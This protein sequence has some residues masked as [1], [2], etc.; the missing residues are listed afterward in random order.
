VLDFP[1]KTPK[2]KTQKEF[3][4]TILSENHRDEMISMKEK[5][6]LEQRFLFITHK[7]NVAEIIDAYEDDEK[8]CFANKLFSPHLGSQGIYYKRRNLSGFTY[9]KKSKKCSLWYGT[10][11]KKLHMLNLCFNH[12]KLDWVTKKTENFKSTNRFGFNSFYR[13]LS[14]TITVGRLNKI[15]SGKISSHRE[16]IEDYN[17]FSLRDINVSN[18]SLYK[19]ITF[20]AEQSYLDFY[21]ALRLLRASINPDNVINMNFLNQKETLFNDKHNI[22]M[23][24]VDQAKILNVKFNPGWS[25]KRL[26]EVHNNWT[27][28]LTGLEIKA[29][30]DDKKIEFNSKELIEEFNEFELLDSKY[31][32]FEEGYNQRH[33]IYTSYYNSAVDKSVFL[34]HHKPSISTI[35]I[36]KYNDKWRIAQHYGKHNSIVDKTIK[37][38][39]EDILLN[40]SKFADFFTRNGKEVPELD[41]ENLHI[42][43]DMPF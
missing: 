7:A 20:N 18:G 11:I 21:I 31:K 35:M 15:L 26:T 32:I 19:L 39:C 27:K 16:Y 9:D 38:K 17:K 4:I 36:N 24:M 12:M 23:D 40:N 14:Q 41:L 2:M 3:T 1:Y 30:G 37:D 13:F 29:L 42:L 33:C 34:F 25:L 10:N 43:I 28:M 8:I 22:V 6:A 5:S